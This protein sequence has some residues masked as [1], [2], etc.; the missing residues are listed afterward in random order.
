LL[1]AEQNVS[2]AASIADRF[3]MLVD[4]QIAMSG[5][6]TELRRPDLLFSRFLG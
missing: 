1:V 6:Q 5:G 2:F 3:V 4:G